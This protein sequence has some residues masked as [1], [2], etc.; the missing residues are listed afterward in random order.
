MT[1]FIVGDR[2]RITYSILGRVGYTGTVV[3]IRDDDPSPNIVYFDSSFGGQYTAYPDRD[4]ERIALFDPAYALDEAAASD[5]PKVTTDTT[6]L[7]DPPHPSA[8]PLWK[9]AARLDRIEAVPQIEPDPELEG[10]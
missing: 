4:L 7:Q 9:L 10:I 1:T 3:A 6:P 5:T 2:V 8:T